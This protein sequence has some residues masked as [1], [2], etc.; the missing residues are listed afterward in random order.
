MITGDTDGGP[1]PAVAV[2][3]RRP[4]AEHHLPGGCDRGT[5]RGGVAP[6]L[7]QRHG[8]AARDR[9]RLYSPLL[10]RLLRGEGRSI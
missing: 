1:A 3:L 10:R 6:V 8:G 9:G 4:R 5:G 7:R 2:L